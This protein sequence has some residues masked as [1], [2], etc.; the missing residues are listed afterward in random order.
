LTADQVIFLLV[1]GLR[2]GVPLLIFRFPLPAIMAALVI[3]AADQ[4]IFQN[5]TDLELT[6]CQ[7]Y[8]KALDIF[9]LA[10]A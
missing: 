5:S 8:D 1:V 7:G 6:G 2:F 10:I 4:T 9:Y 3:D